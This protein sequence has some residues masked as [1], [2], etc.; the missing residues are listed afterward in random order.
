MFD[1]K[2]Q[3]PQNF[4]SY[5]QSELDNARVPTYTQMSAIP[6]ISNRF[7]LKRF[8]GMTEEELAENE[9]LWKEEN[10]ENLT[11]VPTDAAGEMR[12][13]GISGAGIGADMGGM[14]DE[15]LEA[16]VPPE[17]GGTATPPDTSKAGAAPGGGTPP[18][19]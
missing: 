19:A 11:P 1:L 7:A 16:E 6:Y 18:P 2:M 9:R 13:A 12:T 4:A 8:L 5:R 17:D 14:E 10:D 15:D 3:P